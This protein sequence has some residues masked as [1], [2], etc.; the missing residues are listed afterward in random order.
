MLHEKIREKVF[1]GGGV[2]GKIKYYN[3]AFFDISHFISE[4]QNYNIQFPSPNLPTKPS[5][6]GMFCMYMHI[7]LMQNYNIKFPL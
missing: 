6:L 7:S 3:S 1:F 4:M 5:P 2:K